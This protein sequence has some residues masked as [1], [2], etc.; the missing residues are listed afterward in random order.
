MRVRL[1]DARLPSQPDRRAGDY[2]PNPCPGIADPSADKARPTEVQSA[3]GPEICDQPQ[4][5]HIQR[6]VAGKDLLP[7][8][9][10]FQ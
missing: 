6:R 1:L 5:W 9:P 2:V 10:L 8:S 3:A 7:L 4:P